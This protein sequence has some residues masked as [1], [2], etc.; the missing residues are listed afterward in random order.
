MTQNMKA[1]IFKKPGE[2]KIEEIPIPELKKGWVKVKVKSCGMCGGDWFAYGGV[3]ESYKALLGKV[4]GH[5]VSGVVEEINSDDK[6]IKAGDKVVVLSIDPCM[7]CVHCKAGYYQLCNNLGH[8]GFGQ[9]GGFKEYMIVPENLVLK[10]PDKLSYD[11]GALLEPLVIGVH[12][13]HIANISIADSVA[14][15]GAGPIGLAMAA[16][17]KKAGAREIFITSKYK[18]QKIA[19]EAIGIKDILDIDEKAIIDKIMEKT[20]GSGVDSVLVSVGKASKTVEL[21][22]SLITKKGRIV[23]VAPGYDLM[24]IDSMQLIPKE[25]TLMG[26]HAFGVWNRVFEWDLAIDIMLDGLYP[27]SKI[28]THR[29]P[30]DDINEAFEVK[31]KNLDSIKVMINP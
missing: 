26:S 22:F 11:A 2:F 13:I 23:L 20:D 8:L 29:F 16:A 21:S 9:P 30:L 3:F 7:E 19:A 14:V 6:K 28:I 25:I 27:E 4:L 5:E 15:L 24:S 17:A 18:S 31:V 1:A 12:T 10:I